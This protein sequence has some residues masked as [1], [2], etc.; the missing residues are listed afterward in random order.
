MTAVNVQSLTA[1]QVQS[2]TALQLKRA[3]RRIFRLKVQL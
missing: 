1:L 2:L 3:Q